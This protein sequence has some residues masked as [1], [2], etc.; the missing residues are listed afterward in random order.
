MTEIKKTVI[1]NKIKRTKGKSKNYF[2][3]TT[4]ENIEKYLNKLIGNPKRPLK[5]DL[6]NEKDFVGFFT[7]PS[8]LSGEFTGVISGTFTGNVDGDYMKGPNIMTLENSYL[9]IQTLGIGSEKTH[10]SGVFDGRMSGAFESYECNSIYN[11]YIK[12]A[13]EQL[14]H[15]LVHTYKVKFVGE[16]PI[17]VSHDCVAFLYESLYKY[18]P[19]NSTKAKAFSY[20][21]VCAKHWLFGK[22]IQYDKNV[23]RSNDIHDGA[24]EKEI[25]EWDKPSY[26]HNPIDVQEHDE[27]IPIL[28]TEIENW[29]YA[30]DLDD[31]EKKVVQAIQY[32]FEN[33]S[34]IEVINKR[35]VYMFLRDLC[36]LDKPALNKKLKTIRSKYKDFKNIYNNGDI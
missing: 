32:L 23:K 6:L 29:N 11:N 34:N 10:L 35:T 2:D 16:N 19:S 36:G 12:E 14:V 26:M 31:E 22:S 21:N 30:K 7:I 33:S 18:D 4:Q 1:T 17:H 13:F 28:M 25:T 20:F 9:E 5:N 8:Q 15:N 24:I 3:E 27:Y